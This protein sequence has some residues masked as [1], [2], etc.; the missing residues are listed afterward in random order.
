MT[1]TPAPCCHITLHE[2]M[3]VHLPGEEERRSKPFSDSC[4]DFLTNRALFSV[5][6]NI[7]LRESFRGGT[8][9]AKELG[10]RTYAQQTAKLCARAEVGG[11]GGCRTRAILEDEASIHVTLCH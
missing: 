6:V 9:L 10:G 11:R 3:D 8:H 2:N 7:I 1:R 4:R 5:P